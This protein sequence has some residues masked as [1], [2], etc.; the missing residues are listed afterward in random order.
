MKATVQQ[1]Q[2]TSTTSTSNTVACRKCKSTQVVANKRGYSFLNMFLWLVIMGGG[3]LACIALSSFLMERNED[4]YQVIAIIFVLLSTLTIP[5]AILCGFVG[6]SKI[7]NG[8]MNCGHKW[9][10][11]KKN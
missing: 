3:A 7:V 2:R 11:T 10:P 9:M 1:V 8:C 6:R 4:A 5:V